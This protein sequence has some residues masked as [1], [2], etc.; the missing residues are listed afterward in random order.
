MRVRRRHLKS[1]YRRHRGLEVGQT[2]L[3]ASLSGPSLYV[4]MRG[5]IP[6]QPLSGRFSMAAVSRL[7]RSMQ[8]FH[9]MAELLI[10]RRAH[11]LRLRRRY[12]ISPRFISLHA[13]ASLS[14]L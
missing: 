7:P 13:T 10:S 6:F 12:I 1:I 2:L 8:R 11:M 9:W 3:R 5:L 4:T 14:P